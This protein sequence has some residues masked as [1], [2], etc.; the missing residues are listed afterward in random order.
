MAALRKFTFDRVFD[1]PAPA[2]A[3]N[4]AVVE[5]VAATPETAPETPAPPT[6]SEED[7]A[8]ARDEAFAQGHEAGLKEMSESLERETRDAL[9]AVETALRELMW[10]QSAIA[11][12]AIEGAIRVAKTAIRRMLPA[13]AARDP[14]AEIE[15]L[16]SQAMAMIQGEASLNIYVNDRLLEPISTRIRNLAAAEGFGDRITV[17]PLASIAPGDVRVEW[18]N[19]GLSRDMATIEKTIDGVIAHALPASA[20]SPAASDATAVP[21]S[22]VNSEGHHG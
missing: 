14:L 15:L 16:V 22:P 12:D 7:M 3:P 13:L 6:F 19:G 21:S 4:P 11:T 9:T 1:K 17:L 8:A 2:L 10:S 20:A 5:T 18:G